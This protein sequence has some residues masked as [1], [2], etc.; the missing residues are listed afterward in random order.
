MEHLE[1]A[2]DVLEAELLTRTRSAEHREPRSPAAEPEPEPV[3]LVVVARPD[4][5]S[6]RRLQ[7]V[8][9]NG[10]SLGL[11]GVLLG[12]WRP[13]TTVDVRSDGTVTAESPPGADEFT[14]A[15]LFTL[16]AADAGE[17]LELLRE[18][19][20]EIREVAP[21]GPPL[22]RSPS[23]PPT[24]QSVHRRRQKMKLSVLGPVRLTRLPV[25]NDGDDAQELTASLAPKQREILAFLAVHREGERRE[26]ITAA[27]WPD[28][29]SERPYNRFH[30]TVSQL[31]RALRTATH[32]EIHDIVHHHDGRFAL[33]H[34]QVAVD[35]WDLQWALHQ[36]RTAESDDARGAAL[37]QAIDAYT[38]D[39]GVD[40]DS[41]WAEAPREALRRDVLD[42]ISAL[43]RRL[44]R[45]DPGRCLTLMERARVLDRYNEAIYCD[46]MRLQARLGRHAGLP[47]TLSLL[48]TE[49][50]ELDE[51]PS[52]ETV[53]LC[54]SLQRKGTASGDG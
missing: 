8:L 37:E 24:V 27:I 48:S 4:P 33:A 29:P 13:G 16:P 53:A 31:R 23:E 49:L 26:V 19:D 21:Q 11:G 38:G 2:V 54:E 10:F 39:L 41:E 18:A 50:A 40:I 35:V 52:R 25:A 15:R 45:R 51:E 32:D 43:T 12:Q 28:A 36:A 34:D 1:E 22:P 17:L 42:A 5:Q 47:R 7:S 14:G 46:I 3:E 44:S 6:E 9:D 30:A 20:P